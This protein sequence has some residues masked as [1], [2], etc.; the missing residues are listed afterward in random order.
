M[1]DTTGT[2]GTVIDN[3]DGTFNYDPSGLFEALNAGDTATDSFS[4]T[5]SDGDGGFSTA[6]VTITITGVN[7]AT[8]IAA[9]SLTISEG[10]TVVLSAVNLSATD[11]DN[12][13]AQL[14]Y[15]I[16]I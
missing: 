4:Y 13:P 6:T 5:I 16:R 2:L 11:A 10:G 15:T 14:T 1:I 9:N 12:T 8:A 3:G 7:D